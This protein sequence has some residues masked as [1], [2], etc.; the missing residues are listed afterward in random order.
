[1]NETLRKSNVCR[2]L[3][4]SLLFLAF[5]RVPV[6]PAPMEKEARPE[7]ERIIASL[8]EKYEGMESLRASFEQKN[9]L[10][11]LGRTTTSSG[12]LLLQKPGRLRL[13]YREPE[14]QVLV[15]DGQTFWLY[16]PRFRQVVV[17]Q[18][19]RAAFGGPTPLLFL[20]G[21]GDLRK[22]FDVFV[23]EIGI[24][25]RGGGIW[26]AGHPHR[27]RLEPKSPNASFR[28][29]WLEVEAGSFA[30][31]SLAYTDN[32]G[33]RSRLRFSNVEEGVRISG[34]KFRFIAPP[35]VEVVHMPGQPAGDR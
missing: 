19:G 24:A 14:M 30:I 25:R 5:A 26:R 32:L 6:F 13:E 8:Q 16:T 12:S 21:E 10:R 15:S 4:C 3:A 35:H 7:A 22:N 34:E 1:M 17:S 11:T 31:L 2:T 27:I 18:P 9:E 23:E 33:N 20:A 28:R 29:M